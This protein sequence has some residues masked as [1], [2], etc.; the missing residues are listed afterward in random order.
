MLLNDA[1]RHDPS[2][3]EFRGSCQEVTDFYIVERYPFTGDTGMTDE[4]VTTV[5][6]EAK[7]LIERLL[8]QIEQS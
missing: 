3:E 7:H 4:D 1:L 2:L 6:D 5:L 8:S